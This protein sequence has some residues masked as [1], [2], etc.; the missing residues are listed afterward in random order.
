M[1]QTLTKPKSNFTIEEK[2]DWPSHILKAKM[3]LR[4]DLNFSHSVNGWGGPPYYKSTEIWYT[5][6]IL[7]SLVQ[8]E[9]H[10]TLSVQMSYYLYSTNTVN[11][12]RQPGLSGGFVYYYLS[13]L[14]IPA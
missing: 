12:R 1:S 5:H 8:A 14:Q 11:T 4:K 9:Q 10:C 3:C 13:N 7:P 2:L 6:F